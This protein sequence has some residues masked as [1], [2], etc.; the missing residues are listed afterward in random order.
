[1]IETL[2]KKLGATFGLQPGDS[3]AIL[4]LSLPLFFSLTIFWVLKPIKR[5]L[6]LSY[7][8][9]HPLTLFGGLLSGAETEQLV[10]ISNVVAAYLLMLLL[11]WVGYRFQRRTVILALASLSALLL[12]VFALN[13]NDAPPVVIWGFYIFGDMFNT[14]SLVLFWAFVNDSSSSDQAVRRYGL[15]GLG[16]VLGGLAG[17]SLVRWGIVPLGR[18]TI[19]LL[20]LIPL[21]LMTL[22]GLY[23][24]RQAGMGQRPAVTREDCAVDCSTGEAWTL[25]RNSRYLLSLAALVICYEVVSSIA[26]FQFGATVERTITE[27]LRRDAFFGAVGQGQSLIAILVQLFLTSYIMRRFGVG[28]ALLAL[29]LAMLIGTTGYLALPSLLF[30]TLLSISDNSMNFSINQAAKEALYVPLSPVVRTVIKTCNDVLV[31]RCAKVL[32]VLLNLILVP[33]RTMI[34]LRWLS[35]VSLLML[36]GWLFVVR[37]VGRRFATM[38]KQT[39]NSWKKWA[40]TQPNEA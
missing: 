31:Q 8:K 9:A 12:L 7:Y 28:V 11:A 25:F 40:D 35:L 32:G 27:P 6:F 2:R 24:L 1:V 18:E 5:G 3:W 14:A 39:E 33:F 16:G 21:V 38:S 10:K 4:L 30:A 20:C 37:F 23:L 34:D 26:D 29:P 17:S 36:L 19:V 15:I 13:L 22:I